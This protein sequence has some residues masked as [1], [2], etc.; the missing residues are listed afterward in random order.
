M[1]KLYCYADETGQ[2]TRGRFF[3][4][5]LVL[6]EN[7]REELRALLKD[8][9]AHTGKREKKWKK[10]VPRK[11]QLYLEG[12]LSL[13]SLRGALFYAE[14]THSTA[15][16]AHLLDAITKGIRRKA[17]AHYKAT[18]L[19]DGLGKHE[20]KVV[21]A[22]LRRQ[23]IRIEKVRG[24]SEESDEFIRLADA[25]AGFVRDALEGKP[26]ARSLYQTALRQGVLEKL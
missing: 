9:E 22:I 3:A 2:D 20:R 5:A 23:G 19:I 13:A 1:Q 24:L 8:I 15:Y 25:I 4:V 7:E 17:S 14:Y 21:G 10:T 6:I 11:K 26:H 16:P 18:V 12:V